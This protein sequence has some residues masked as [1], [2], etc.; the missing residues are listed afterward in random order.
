[1]EDLNHGRETTFL[2]RLTVVV[3]ATW[4]WGVCTFTFVN[5]SSHRHWYLINMDPHTGYSS[6]QKTC[7]F[8][9]L[10]FT[11]TPPSDVYATSLGKA[12]SP[13]VS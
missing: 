12:A 5:M 4:V 2:G 10:N 1:M 11:I 6:S 7:L 8:G 13:G 3:G 9:C